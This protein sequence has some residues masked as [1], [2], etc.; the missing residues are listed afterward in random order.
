MNRRPK[1]E[2]PEGGNTNIVKAFV[3]GSYARH[4]WQDKEPGD[5]EAE[6]ILVEPAVD[7]KQGIRPKA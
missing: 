6:E 7:G 2:K 4:P 1:I 5:F 3:V